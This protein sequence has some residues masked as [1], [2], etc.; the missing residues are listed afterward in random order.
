MK[1]RTQRLLIASISL[2]YLNEVHRL[3]SRP[4]VDR[5]NTLGIPASTDVTKKIMLGWLEKQEADPATGYVFFIK[6]I[7]SNEFIGLAGLNIGKPNYSM[8]EIW[9]KLD[10]GHW[11]KGY[12]SE[13]VAEILRMGFTK[14]KLHRI[15]AG[16]AVDNTASIRVLEKAGFTREGR[17]RSVLPVRGEWL[18]NYFYA[19][20]DTDY[21][22][23][24]KQS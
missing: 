23:L 22:T 21:H 16:C 20:L 6:L 15:E 2:D 12:A 3:H 5:F 4:E 7:D 1:F 11:N 9:Y 19:I 14:L 13:V 10:P 18:D 24:N 17:K 8:G